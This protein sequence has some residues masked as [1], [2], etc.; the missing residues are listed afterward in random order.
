MKIFSTVW[1]TGKTFTVNQAVNYLG[2]AYRCTIAHTAGGTFDSSKFATLAYNDFYTDPIRASFYRENFF[3]VDLVYIGIPDSAGDVTESSVLRLCNG[4]IDVVT[5][6]NTYTAQGD[7]INFSN[8]TEEFDVK[9]GKFSVYIS[10]LSSG[11]VDKFIG[12][13]F[14]GKRVTIAKAFLNYQTL[15][16]INL[17][18]IVFDGIIYNVAVTESAVTCT[19]DVQC[20]TLWAD[21]E[22][23][24]GRMTNNN[25]NWL[26]Q[27]GV[28]TDR[29]FD[30]TSTAGQVEY[31]W[32]RN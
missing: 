21:F 25:S 26:F 3:A 6:G 31:K 10:G 11:M 5:S 20:A 32:G 2:Y 13:D 17:P 1:A 9:V 14:E 16:V 12:R 22:R 28:S 7:F 8:V 24:T 19:I 15:E 27:R 18:Y 23:T 4:G 30:K 29:S